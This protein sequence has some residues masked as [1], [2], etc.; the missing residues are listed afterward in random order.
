MTKAVIW[1]AVVCLYLGM[2]LEPTSW[3]F[4]HA[5][6]L[7][8]LDFLYWGYSAFRTGGFALSLWPYYWIVCIAAGLIVALWIRRREEK[9]QHAKA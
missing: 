2:G 5:S 8:G 7:P 4:Y 1:G 3:L 9:K 6:F